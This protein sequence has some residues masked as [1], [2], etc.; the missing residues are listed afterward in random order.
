MV[1]EKWLL[2]FQAIAHSL[3]SWGGASRVPASA[4]WLPREGG[5]AMLRLGPLQAVP[6]RCLLLAQRARSPVALN[7]PRC[8]SAGANQLL[9]S[10]LIPCASGEMS[11]GFLEFAADT[12]LG[13]PSSKPCCRDPHRQ[14]Q[15]LGLQELFKGEWI[16]R[17]EVSEFII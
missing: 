3:G 8:G 6:P 9:A 4:S 5:E 13:L 12:A 17:F 1:F 16:C 14:A 15:V 2:I 10:P 7:P 11:G